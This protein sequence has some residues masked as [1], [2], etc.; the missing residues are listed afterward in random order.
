MSE[1][2]IV[3]QCPTCGYMNSEYI[4]PKK[5]HMNI[6]CEDCG[7]VFKVEYELEAVV[8]STEVISDK[9]SYDG[10]ESDWNDSDEDIEL[11]EED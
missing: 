11:D 8:L 9:G 3:A 1:I 10:E 6:S 2:E 4:T 7:T 5:T